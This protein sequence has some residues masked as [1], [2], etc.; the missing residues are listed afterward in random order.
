MNKREALRV[1]GVD[2]EVG[3]EVWVIETERCFEKCECCGRKSEQEKDCAS[4]EIVKQI[5]FTC[6]TTKKC[7]YF[8]LQAEVSDS[9]QLDRDEIFLTEEECLAEIKRRKENE[10]R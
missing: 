4:S 7:T 10:L 8:E 3:Q 5:T 2:L 1:L 9:W 6:T